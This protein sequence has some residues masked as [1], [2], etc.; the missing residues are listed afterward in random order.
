MVAADFSDFTVCVSMFPFDGTAANAVPVTM[1][2]PTA[3]KAMVFIIPPLLVS[4]A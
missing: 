3:N 1:N 2:A 4:P